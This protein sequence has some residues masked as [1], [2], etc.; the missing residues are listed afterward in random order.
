MKTEIT[1]GDT[2]W[3]NLLK[4]TVF[5][6]ILA[7]IQFSLKNKPPLFRF[8]SPYWCINSVVKTIADNGAWLLL[9]NWEI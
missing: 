4:F 8:I 6:L 7:L 1:V 5:L 9:I 2:M 3:R